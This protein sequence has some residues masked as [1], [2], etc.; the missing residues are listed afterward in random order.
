MVDQNNGKYASVSKPASN[1]GGSSLENFAR[2][3]LDRLISDG[4]PPI[5]YNYK[6]YF[7]NELDNESSEFRKQVYELIALE[8]SNDL[9]KDL[10]F[11]KKLKDSF[12]YS[13][14]LLNHVTIIYKLNK[15]LKELLQ[16]QLKEASHLTNNKA[17][18]KLISGFQNNLKLIDARLSK[19]MN[20]IKNIYSKNVEALKAIEKNS[21]YDSK[22]GVYNKNY[23]LNEVKKELMLI[24][25]FHHISSIITVKVKDEIFN[26]L[27][28]EK[29][30]VLINRSLAKIM[31]KTSRR[32]DVVAKLDE[33]IFAMLLKHTDVIGAQRTVE[34]LSDAI[35]N[36]AVFLEGEEL[37]L[38]IVAGIVELK[39]N[40]EVE[41]FIS[42]ALQALKEAEKNNQLYLI[43]KVE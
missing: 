32:T 36:A 17:L 40:K 16:M 18:I 15:K 30:K 25:K 13:K 29:S 9:E 37:E 10:E 31:L 41:I 8:E 4:V 14:E 28:S 24:G 5:P 22:Y 34:R 42:K 6:V 21:I 43:E 7:L 12:K 35:S 26:K 38:Q 27:E 33:N 1:S 39:E 11:E 3:V 20:E 2:R 23:F 19:E